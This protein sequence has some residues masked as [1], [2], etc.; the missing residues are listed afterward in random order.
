MLCLIAEGGGDGQ[1]PAKKSVCE[2]CITYSRGTGGGSC[3]EVTRI[4]THS[5][6]SF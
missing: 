4:H 2:K 3:G 1:T 6:I 5:N